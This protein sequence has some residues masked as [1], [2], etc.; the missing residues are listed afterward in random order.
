MARLA[1]RTPVLPGEW[2]MT[3][4]RMLVSLLALL[5]CPAWAVAAAKFTNE[6]V[7]KLLAAKIP[8]STVVLTVKASDA[9]FD[10]STDAI[11]ALS[12]KGVP[13]AVIAAM[14]EKSSGATAA[15]AAADAFNPEEIVLQSG[16]KTA[17][18]RYVHSTTRSAPRALGLGGYATYAVLPGP[19]ANLRLSDPVPT[20][21]VAVPKNAQPE[22]Y[23]MARRGLL[24][25]GWGQLLRLR[26]GRV[27]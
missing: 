26:A 24:R 3:T 16:D 11:I 4:I 1:L 18:L 20:F 9:D 22:N 6:D 17:N 7:L 5:L 27:T 25:S 8:V 12:E 21:I 23:T 2:V 13:E 10:T 15:S 14:L 19:K